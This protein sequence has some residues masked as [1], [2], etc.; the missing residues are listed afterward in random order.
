MRPPPTHYLALG[1]SMSVDLYP[2]LDLEERGSTGDDAIAGG[3]IGAASLLY[4][5]ASSLWPEFEGRDLASRFPEIRFEN[6]AVDG[7]TI[8]DVLER[9]IPEVAARHGA[10]AAIVTVTAGGN[11]LLDALFAVG[12]GEMLGREVEKVAT[13]CARMAEALRKELPHALLVLTTTYDPTDRTGTLPGLSEVFGRLPIHHLDRFNDRVRAVAATTRGAVLADVHR[14]FLGH[15]VRAPEAERWYWRH[16]MIEPNAR[17][18]S[19]IRRVWLEALAERLT[20]P[21]AG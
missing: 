13:A 7:G 18:A 6:H 5:N 8:A 20:P 11:D 14:H 1:D 21:A 4:R 9:Q 2:R 19:E 10:A 3:R 12:P 16:G 15:G 17:G